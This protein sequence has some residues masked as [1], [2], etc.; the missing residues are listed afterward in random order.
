MKGLAMRRH[1]DGSAPALTRA[2]KPWDVRLAVR[3]G[4]SLR[5]VRAWLGAAA[6]FVFGVAGAAPAVGVLPERLVVRAEYDR[7]EQLQPLGAWFGHLVVDPDAKV[8]MVETD[9]IGRRR[10][11]RL[12]FRVEIAD[13]ATRAVNRREPIGALAK[14]IGGLVCYRTVE[15]TF[16]AIDALAAARPDLVEVRDIGQSWRM[17]QGLGGHPLRVV[18]VTNT[19]IPGPKPKLFVMSSVHARE[20]TPAETMTRFVEQLVG[21]HG[22]DPDL[23]WMV[24]H[25]EVHA[26]LQANPDGRKIA[27]TQWASNAA[28][29]RKNANTNFCGAGRFGIDLNRNYP[30]GWNST[31]GQGSSGDPC[32][33]TFRGPAPASEP[34]T[35][36]VAAYVRSIFPDARGDLPTD[37]APD[38]TPGIFIDMHSY[39]RLVL[40]PWGA[41]N[42]VAPNGGP[43][44]TLGRRLAWFNGYRPQQSTGLYLTDGTTIDFAYGELG[45]ASLTFE[46]GVAFFESCGSFQSTVLPDNLR[47]LT[48]ALRVARAPYLLPAGPETR[49]LAITPDL[50]VRGEPAMLSATVDDTRFSTENAPPN[51]V[52]QPQHPIVGAEAF[53]GT[54]PWAPAASP[55]P[56]VADDGAF[57]APVEV[58]RGALSTAG[59]AAGRHLVYVR[60]RDA[61]AD[62]ARAT[63][64]VAAGFLR[65]VEAADLATLSGR[66]TAAS[67]GEPV[68]A[69]VR[70]D[71]LATTSDPATGQYVRTLAPGNFTLAVEATGY[72]PFRLDPLAV[73]PGAQLTRDVALYRYCARLADAGEPGQPTAFIAQSPWQ[74]LAGIGVGGS[75]AWIAGNGTSYPANANA[76]LTSAPLDLS[77][78]DTVILR[79]QQRCATQARFDFGIVE[80]R[81]H[82]GAAW[83]EVHRCEGDPAWRR[84]E[85]ALPQLAGAGAAEIRFRF[86]SDASTSAQGF[87]V[88]DIVLE[89][90]G[91]AC[92]T[93]QNP[94][95]LFRNGFESVGGA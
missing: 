29:Q 91:E 11:E 93:A 44:Q 30:F 89:A 27:E 1:L 61:N 35:D 23:T 83:T 17:V 50:V 94:E 25:H 49:A 38:D 34:E 26:L 24:D 57:D 4:T 41:T 70:V 45:V 28:G 9:P 14:A 75:G 51:P 64:P 58:V 80:V 46:L 76:S 15:E 16:A 69:T 39:S 7:P 68:A 81:A 21:G 87:A 52:I 60:G 36:A 84:I 13:E 77:A 55:I 42:T 92:R 47:A 79:F 72:E 8:L 43:L 12:G 5:I 82:P 78:D 86:T 56:L 74:R 19:A 59:L 31:G 18:R 54:P 3:R 2:S 10:L 90:T 22:R 32:S 62:A 85:L 66:I 73:P 95:P 88:D 65:V 33:D 53:V 71:D 6:I 67:T 20:Y 63:G 37:P 48:Y 40:W